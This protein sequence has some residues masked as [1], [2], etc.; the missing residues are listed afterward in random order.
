MLCSDFIIFCLF[1]FSM[2]CTINF[3]NQ[4]PVKT[5]KICNI[6]ANDMLPSEVH[7][8]LFVPQM[9]PQVILSKSLM[10]S[11]LP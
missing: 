1:T 9:F 4:H 7:T 10:L 8:H 3:N 5:D 6:V 2:V 11:V